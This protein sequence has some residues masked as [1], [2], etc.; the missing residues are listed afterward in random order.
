MLLS[1]D[2]PRKESNMYFVLNGFTAD[3]GSRVFVFESIQADRS[4]SH[5]PLTVTVDLALARKYG[6]R[7]QDLPLLCRSVLERGHDDEKKR[8]YTYTEEEMR[9][10]AEGVAD[11]EEAA[12]HT[13][14]PRRSAGARVNGS[15][16]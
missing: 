8:A 7:L 9:L 6:I 10:H 1:T 13:K 12:R 5:I 15:V 14:P 3:M 16:R 2:A 4:R 11:R